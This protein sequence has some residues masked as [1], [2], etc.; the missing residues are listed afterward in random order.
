MRR[1]TCVQRPTAACPRLA[2]LQQCNACDTHCWGYT[3]HHLPAHNS[4]LTMPLYENRPSP[5]RHDVKIDGR[6]RLLRESQELLTIYSCLGRN[7]VQTTR[8]EGARIP[9]RPRCSHPE[10]RKWRSTRKARMRRVQYRVGQQMDARC[11]VSAVP[12]SAFGRHVQ[13]RTASRPQCCKRQAK[14]R[15]SESNAHSLKEHRPNPWPVWHSP[16][17]VN[18]NQSSA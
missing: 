11:V 7:R 2:V 5:T 6:Q 1:L 18:V 4:R 10:V 13:E 17:L 14:R 16:G 3:S 12:C 15:T 9:W 8:G